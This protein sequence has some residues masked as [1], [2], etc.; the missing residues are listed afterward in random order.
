MNIEQIGC[1]Y[2]SPEGDNCH[3]YKDYISGDFYMEV[4]TNNWDTCSNDY[5]YV[6]VYINC[7][8]MCGRKL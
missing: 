1:D 5:E 6:K 8:P 2:C 3:V 7:C 4:K